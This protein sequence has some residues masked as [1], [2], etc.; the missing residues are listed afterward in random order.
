[1]PLLRILLIEDNPADAR[2]LR[3]YILDG[4]SEQEQF[5]IL[6]A[7]RLAEGVE[8]LAK[9]PVDIVL[10]DLGL[11]DSQGIDSFYR[12]HAS[13]PNI[14]VILLTGHQ[15]ERTAALAVQAGAQ[16][17]LSK[18][19]VNRALLVRALRYAIERQRSHLALQASEQR[20]RKMIDQNSIAILVVALNGS[21]L[22]ANPA[23]VKMFGKEAGELLG[24][25]F[26]YPISNNL[27]T[28]IAIQNR[29]SGEITAEMEVSQT[30]WEGQLV[31]LIALH[32]I[33]ARKMAEE[34]R[35]AEQN[36]TE[37]LSELYP[38]L[39]STD[40]DIHDIACEILRRACQLT[41]S[42]AGFIVSLN[43]EN[44]AGAQVLAVMTTENGS[45]RL[46]ESMN[47]TPI[48]RD[49]HGKYIGLFGS[50]LNTHEPFYGNQIET[51]Q[52]PSG[53]QKQQLQIKRYLAVPVLLGERLVGQ[54]AILN[55]TA[56]Y[57]EFD[58]KTVQ[59]LAEFYGLALQRW[60]AENALRKARDESQRLFQAE[61]EQRE[62]AETMREVVSLLVSATDQETIFRRLLEQVERVVP[63]TEAVIYLI[64]G[65]YI[66]AVQ[67]LGYEKFHPGIISPDTVFRI[68]DFPNIKS[69]MKTKQPVLNTDTYQ[70]PDWVVAPGTAHI[71]SYAGVPIRVQGQVTG[72]LNVHHT[73]PGFYTARHLA[74]LSIFGD[75]VAIALENALLLDE[76]RHR[77]YELE[78]I[79][80]VSA[81]LRTAESLD[82]ML[83][84]FMDGLLEVA[85][86]LSGAIFLAD[87]VT[88]YLILT[89]RRG[90]YENFST[91]P[92]SPDTGIVGKVF[93]TGQACFSSDFLTDS[94]IFQETINQVPAGVSELC[95][96]LRTVRETFGVLVLAFQAS[97]QPST[98]E[99]H[100]IETLV[101]I[102]GNTFHRMRLHEETEIRLQYLSTLR[103]IDL[104][105]AT[106]F[107]LRVT[108]NVLLEQT[109]TQLA[110]D[111]ADILLFNP[112]LQTLDY[113]AS[114]GFYSRVVEQTHL[115]IGQGFA[116][117]AVLESRTIFLPDLRDKNIAVNS[118]DHLANE[119]FVTYFGIPLMIKGEIKGVLELFQRSLF[120]PAGE[121]QDFLDSLSRQA[122]IAIDNA[123]LFEN[124][125]RSRLELAMAYDYTLE[126]WSRALDLRDRETEHHTERVC[127]KSLQLAKRMGMNENELTHIRRGALLHDIGK[128]GVPDY[129]LLKP[130]PLTEDEWV[131]MRKHPDIAR[132]LLSPIEYL[133]PALDIP[134][135]HHEHWDGGGY[136]RG[137][138]GE[139]IPKAA[140]IFFVVDVWDALS[141]DRPYRGAW[142]Q[143]KVI[144][145][146]REQAGKQLDPEV[147][148]EFILML[149][150]EAL[151]EELSKD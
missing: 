145:Y 144:D 136:P 16:D 90:Q 124:L 54:V 138:K 56:D 110:V 35:Q 88:K 107:D 46:V 96:P 142:P 85:D 71:R 57:G 125:Q 94:K 24:G 126:G 74:L 102:A 133:H 97:H 81:S 29:S 100:L 112:V 95:L 12:L 2:L 122:A 13:A 84:I 104:A 70:H 69:M 149:E 3:E 65:D 31:Y 49:A 67:W 62:L 143:E 80:K 82:E 36:L 134:Y 64:E 121:W 48:T 68:D 91:P 140:R 120:R 151:D 21:V 127:E 148:N 19:E 47:N 37:A 147:V 117:Q 9:N 26:G 93:T 114:K 6:S 30:T 113:G 146:L 141:N 61:H 18:T 51:M 39:I 111:A 20:L 22:F 115:H 53:C 129:I 7:S 135:C 41:H 52:E 1:M 87:P 79:N 17:Y 123:Q 130:G 32:D 11:P 55:A 4:D 15:D 38:P 150:E 50:V 63:F 34:E 66:R 23:A 60:E 92:I 139:Q 76:K 72:F 42:S 14:P 78:V 33:T 44:Q 75:E 116:G 89:I 86:T 101:D 27:K 73:Q 99:K 58:L 98:S 77:I 119:R 59:R 131:I 8:M 106:S 132:D 103:T 43:V 137:L 105:I 108:L 128:M 45:L 118:F 28:E 5:Q 40:T 25:E 109:L 83:P 10:L